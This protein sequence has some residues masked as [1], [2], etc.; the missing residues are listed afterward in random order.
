MAIIEVQNNPTIEMVTVQFICPSCKSLYC[1]KCAN[2][3]ANLEN[4]CWSC[5]KTIDETKDTKRFKIEDESVKI[6]PPKME[7][8]KNMPEVPQA[9]LDDIEKLKKRVQNLELEV[10]KIKM[11]MGG[12]KWL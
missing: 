12:K 2:A 7:E 9:V 10:A 3:L 5:D 1:E 11:K 4:F 8:K 6:Q